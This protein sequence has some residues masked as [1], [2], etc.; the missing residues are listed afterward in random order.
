MSNSQEII[1]QTQT[2]YKFA[3]ISRHQPTQEQIDLAKEKNIEL[4]PIGDF[5]GFTVTY[6]DISNHGDFDGVICAHAAMALRLINYYFIGIYENGQ[7]P[8]IN[9]NMTFKAIDLIFYSIT[10]MGIKEDFLIETES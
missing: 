10:T 8:D 9:G 1:T 6:K 5:D 4:V 7:R 3:F 2:T